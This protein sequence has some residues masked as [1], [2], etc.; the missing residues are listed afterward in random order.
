MK[1][2]KTIKG[3]IKLFRQID[4]TLSPTHLKGFDQLNDMDTEL[5]ILMDTDISNYINE[6]EAF[7]NETE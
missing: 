7:P 3:Y 5:L 2:P 6:V 1:L 4:N